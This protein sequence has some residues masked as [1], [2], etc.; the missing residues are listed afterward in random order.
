MTRRKERQARRNLA[1]AAGRMEEAG[2]T[3]ERIT[4]A[5]F[6]SVSRVVTARRAVELCVTSEALDQRGTIHR[7]RR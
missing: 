7:R 1:L 2:A 6:A 3:E 5:G 4:R